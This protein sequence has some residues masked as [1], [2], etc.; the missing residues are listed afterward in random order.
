MTMAITTLL[1]YFVARERWGWPLWAVAPLCTFFFA[2]DLAFFRANVLKIPQGGWF[3]LVVATGIFTLMTTWKRGRMILAERLDE[4][5][6]PFDEF[7]EHVAQSSPI[8]IPRHGCI[9]VTEAD[10][11]ALLAGRRTSRSTNVCT[12]R[13]SCSP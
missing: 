13:L 4:R 6:A 5:V 9:Y 7:L 11:H 10:R 2:V 1:F 8:R 3:P 12:S